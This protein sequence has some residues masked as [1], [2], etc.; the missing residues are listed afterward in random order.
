M[1]KLATLLAATGGLALILVAF[2]PNS[3]AAWAWGWRYYPC[4]GP[5]MYHYPYAYFPY[6]RCQHR[7][8]GYGWR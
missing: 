2:T 3:S 5:Y 7:W 4:Y 6:W 8:V 1:K